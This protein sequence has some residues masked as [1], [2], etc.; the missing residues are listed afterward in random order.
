MSFRNTFV[1]DFIYQASD[2]VH[3]ANVNVTAVF[4]KHATLFHQVDK[5]GYGF[6][7]GIIKTLDGSLKSNDMD[8]DLLVREL[9]KATRVPFRITILLESGPMVTY[10][11]KP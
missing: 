7:A 10:E 4:E 6:Y 5:R 2:E 3:H 11:I 8:L 1:T 9:E